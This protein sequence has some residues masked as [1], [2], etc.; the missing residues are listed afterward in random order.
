MIATL[1]LLF[2]AQ[3]QPI[4]ISELIVVERV[5]SSRRSA[6]FTDP[7]EEQLARGTWA[8]PAAGAS[9]AT[10]DGE[11]HTWRRI[12]ASPGGGFQDGALRGG[13]A[14]ARVE[15]ETQR[16]L[17]LDGSGYRHVYVNGVPHV[18]DLYGMGI[19]RIPI[20]LLAGTNE[21]LFK[22]GR[23]SLRAR[24][25]EPPGEGV[26]FERRDATLPDLVAGQEG[27]DLDAAVLVTR[28]APEPA[29]VFLRA[30]VAGLE[31]QVLVDVADAGSKKVAFRV[32]VPARLEGASMAL[33][34]ELIAAERVIDTW[35]L[36]LGVRAASDR[37][38][39]T[40]VSAIDASVQYF[41]V[42]P[43][44]PETAGEAQPGLFLSL[45]GAGVEATGQAGAYRP[46]SR[47]YV[48]APTNRRPYGFDW[49][50]W[51][52]LDALEV[53]ARAQELFAT[54]PARTY[55]TGHSMGGHGT[56]NVA[57]NSPGRFAA[58]APSAGWRDFWSYGGAGEWEEPTPVEERLARA[59]NASR[60]LDLI[61][62]LAPAGVYVLHGDADDNVPV[63]QARFM[64]E[65]LAQFHTNWAYYERPGAGHWWGNACVD[66]DP[67][68]EFFSH[69][70]LP[71]DRDV[72]ELAFATFNPAIAST[73]RWASI[74]RQRRSM[75]LSRIE[76]ELTASQRRFT[77]KT[78]NVT[79]LELDWS[80][81]AAAP[82]AA[83]GDPVLPRGEPV[84][85]EI[86]GESLEVSW[87]EADRLALELDEAW[88][89]AGAVSE[90]KTPARAG[91]FKRAFE[92]DCVLV[93]ATGGEA[94]DW[95]RGKALYDAQTFWYR[96][97]GSLSVVADTDFDPD[98]EHDRDRNVVLY[99]NADSHALW[100]ELLGH[101]PIDV[102]DGLVRVGERTLAGDDL[103]CLFVYPRLGSER[104]SV[105][106][107]AGSGPVGMRC[108]NQLPYFV[109]GVG[110]PDWIVLSADVFERG[111]EGVHG[112]GYFDGRWSLAGG[113]AGW[114]AEVSEAPS[115]P[116]R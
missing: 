42:T 66:W 61:A 15:L 57:V 53:L 62:N 27:G 58:I 81:L 84:T 3:A 85:I 35:E 33:T 29:E 6:I 77:L 102:R 107:V 74:Q 11:V 72:L 54:D 41:A 113:D 44:D 112:A 96:G 110:Y 99:G 30:R 26:F 37:H 100:S 19:V 52:R 97:N 63:S 24:L 87:P 14:A 89:V 98:S 78:E 80:A 5:T 68:F 38:K 114:R 76:A 59:A 109:S 71:P 106:A 25:V 22:A 104:A 47:G 13:Y 32:A 55:L 45:H 86:D 36:E 43:P 73:C 108:T 51:G 7:V 65:E 31:R 75:E 12:E 48:V 16:V 39:R 10:P 8:F 111:S 9:I 20:R 23:G 95:A 91:P 69:N 103:A 83:G 18:G 70:V 60:T 94:E 50:D 101:A 21:L 56:W 28:V 92:N 116:G 90:G 34:L 40:F 115:S 46:R 88:A 17:L 67:M 82:D 2:A 93:Y 1:A 4:E 49:E 64:R 79:R 105:A